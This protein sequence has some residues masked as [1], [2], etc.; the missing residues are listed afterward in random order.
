MWQLLS[1]EQALQKKKKE[2]IAWATKSHR[3]GV[4]VILSTVDRP[5]FDLISKAQMVTCWAA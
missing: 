1:Y 3:I 5:D 2:K 4:I